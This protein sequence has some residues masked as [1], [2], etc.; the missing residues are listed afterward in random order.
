MAETTLK[1]DTVERRW[2]VERRQP[3]GS[4]AKWQHPK[5]GKPSRFETFDGAV[6]QAG[7]KAVRAGTARVG[8][9]PDPT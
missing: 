7:K 9:E 8:R 5:A 2:Y 1:T 4:W 6:A 3:D